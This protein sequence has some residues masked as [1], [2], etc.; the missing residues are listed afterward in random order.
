MTGLGLVASTNRMCN[1]RQKTIAYQNQNTMKTKIKYLVYPL[2][3]ILLCLFVIAGCS[4]D[5][6]LL[7]DDTL[8]IVTDIDGNVY[9]TVIIGNQEWM[10]EN[11][12]VTKYNNGDAI[13]TGLSNEEWVNTTE[14]AYAIYDH[15][16]W[17][18]DGINSPVEMV[19]AYGKLYNWY[20]VD[21][22]RGLCPEGW[23]VPNDDDWAQLVDYVVAQGYPNLGG[24]PNGAG[25]A[26]KSCRQVNSPIN[27]YCD[28]SEHPRWDPHTTHHGFDK[29]GF[30]AIPVGRRISVV[31]IGEFEGIGDFV[32]WWSAS[33]HSSS[34]AWSF[35]ISYDF[36]NVHKGNHAKVSGFG[37]RCIKD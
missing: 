2:A 24:N 21:D 33:E 17:N 11:L 13:P 31:S 27:G 7:P 34:R 29:F 30:S 25:N 28:T 23:S 10:A 15:N 37:V 4:D 3:V 32:L 16:E 19:A 22:I 14:G 35:A 9:Q 12:R 36:G 8:G 6:E 1:K 5:D 18:T 20:A 26:L